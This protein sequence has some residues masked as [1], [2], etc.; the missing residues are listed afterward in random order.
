MTE[1]VLDTEAL[2]NWIASRT[3]TSDLRIEID[4]RPSGGFSAETILLTAESSSNGKQRFVVRLETP[5]PAV[6][7]AQSDLAMPEIE[8]QFRIMDSISRNS[9]LPIAALVGYESNPEVL[10]TP[11]FVMHHVD[12]DVPISSV[13]VFLRWHAFTSSTHQLSGWTGSFLVALPLGPAT[14][15]V[16]GKNLAKQSCAGERIRS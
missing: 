1:S 16:S 11:F 12:G 13:M 7:P 9:H 5:E 3:G 4:G 2:G 8:I 10:G 15:F 14:F 6:Y